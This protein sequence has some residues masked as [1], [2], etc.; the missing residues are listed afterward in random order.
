MSEWF[1]RVFGRQPGER[2]GYDF[3]TLQEGQEVTARCLG[4]VRVVRT[5]FG[6]RPFLDVELE[7]GE[8]RTLVLSHVDLAEKIALIEQ[9]HGKLEGLRL[10]I[11]RLP[12]TGRKALY[13]VEV[14]EG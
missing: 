12:S 9:E 6:N 7:G 13:E 1:Q 14:L 3:L 4:E 2:T 8:R 11:K 10:R 5:R